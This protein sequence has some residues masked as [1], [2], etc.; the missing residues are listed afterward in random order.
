MKSLKKS[1]FALKQK[2]FR[3]NYLFPTPSFLVGFGSVVDLF[4]SPLIHVSSNSE[5]DADRIEMQ[6]DFNMIGQD[7]SDAFKNEKSKLI[8]TE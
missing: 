8:E 5:S 1:L 4:G 6:N 7:I 3:T 2:R